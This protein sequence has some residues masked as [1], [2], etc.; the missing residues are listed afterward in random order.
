MYDVGGGDGLFTVAPAFIGIIFVIILILF[1]VN[2]FNGLSQWKKNEESPRLSVPA[3]VISKRTN[4]T[5]HDHLHDPHVHSQSSSYFITWEFDSGD[6]TEFRISGKEFGLLAEGDM[7]TL[8][9][10][11]TRFIDFS[12]KKHTQEKFD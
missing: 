1:I 11:G 6:R 10:Q 7:G 12:R 8:T 3:H 5:R 2:A 9:F 4:V